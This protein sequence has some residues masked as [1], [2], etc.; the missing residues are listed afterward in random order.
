MPQRVA[1]VPANALEE[2][3][4]RLFGKLIHLASEACFILPQAADGTGF[5]LSLLEPKNTKS[6]E[7][8]QTLAQRCD[9]EID[10][11]IKGTQLMGNMGSKGTSSS[12]AASKEV[13]KEDSDYAD[14]DCIKLGSCL[15]NQLWKPFCQFN[16]GDPELAP[17]CTYEEL[18]DSDPANRAKVWVDV[19]AACA[20]FKQSG[21]NV[22]PAEVKEE[23]GITLEV[24]PEPEEPDPAIPEKLSRFLEAWDPNQSRDEKG[25]WDGGSGGSGS[26]AGSSKSIK[27]L[28]KSSADIE[29]SH[30]S[31]SAER[32][33]GK[34]MALFDSL[35]SKERAPFDQYIEGDH[36]KIRK[37]QIE[38]KGDHLENAKTIDRVIAREEKYA[39]PIQMYRGMTLSHEQ[40]DQLMKSDSIDLKATSSFS[41]VPK[42]ATDFAAGKGSGLETGMKGKIPVVIHGKLK[43]LSIGT[44]ELDEHEHL[45]RGKS[46]KIVSRTVYNHPEHGPV[47]VLEVSDEK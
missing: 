27:S 19:G 42:T 37:A 9:S 13:R 5:D 46:L 26:K 7:V 41:S 17:I 22:D 15:R 36:D 1:K 44:K 47:L 12:M 10:L 23:F 21:F 38:G 16:H 6:W 2:D 35:S 18:P 32:E 25:M 31:V 30:A 39:E 14:S 20:S 34:Q 29:S 8:F 11:A 3:K 24:A 4:A 28:P 45:V 40:A 43:G 33:R